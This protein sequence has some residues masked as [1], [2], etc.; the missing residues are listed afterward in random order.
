MALIVKKIDGGASVIII[1]R[2][3]EGLMPWRSGGEDEKCSL[4]LFA[5]A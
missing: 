1:G 3:R 2:K 5:N 4:F